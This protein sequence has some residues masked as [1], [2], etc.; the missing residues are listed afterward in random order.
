M[1]KFFFIIGMSVLVLINAGCSFNKPTDNIEDRTEEAVSYKGAIYYALCPSMDKNNVVNGGLYKMDDNGKN[2]V[3]LSDQL[4][5]NINIYDN[6]IYYS[7]VSSVT[8]GKTISEENAG[9]FKMK[10]DGSHKVKIYD[11]TAKFLKV[12][13]NNIYFSNQEDNCKLYRINTDGTNEKK[14]NDDSSW[15]IAV[16][17]N[18]IYYSNNPYDGHTSM[19]LPLD[20]TRGNIYKITAEG[21]EKTKL[22]SE[23]GRLSKV[24]GGW[25]Y[26]SNLSD[27]K[28]Y[29][30]KLD[31]SGKSPVK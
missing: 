23:T 18:W 31:G 14:L 15:D 12:T 6:W 19:T 16:D 30:M 26:Y 29:K 27:N 8:R 9:I 13:G 3:Q 5:S 10:T 20:Q 24:L 7:G 11:K 25:I 17:G 21:N 1:K 22:N 28:A 4:V 2:K